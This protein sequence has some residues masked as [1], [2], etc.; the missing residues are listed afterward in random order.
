LL[1]FSTRALGVCDVSESPHAVPE[2]PSSRDSGRSPGNFC[3][4]FVLSSG[5]SGTSHGTCCNMKTFPGARNDW[6]SFV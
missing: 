5:S 6:Q 1:L 2:L 4:L 3:T